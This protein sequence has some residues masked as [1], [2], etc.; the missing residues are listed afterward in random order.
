M[1][2]PFEDQ[3]LS[4]QLQRP[5]YHCMECCFLRRNTGC[6]GW[7]YWIVDLGWISQNRI[8]AE[9]LWTAILDTGYSGNLEHST[10]G[11]CTE[12]FNVTG[13]SNVVSTGTN[14]EN[15]LKTSVETGME[16]VWNWY[17]MVWNFVEFYGPTGITLEWTF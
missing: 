14:C 2:N 13:V 3:F 10:S 16:L 7:I 9:L 15:V 1:S 11:R 8:C 6:T 17:G 5:L 12:D 4:N